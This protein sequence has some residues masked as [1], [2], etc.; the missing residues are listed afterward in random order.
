MR[1]PLDESV[2]REGGSRWYILVSD[3]LQS[4]K[5]CEQ[6]ANGGTVCEIAG[7]SM[8][9]SVLLLKQVNVSAN[10]LSVINF[11]D[12]RKRSRVEVN[13]QSL[14]GGFLRAFRVNFNG[15]VDRKGFHQSSFLYER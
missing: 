2:G 7:D 13:L 3:G 15:P 11:E 6:L 5:S 4:S 8:R 10:A 1:I 14:S 9:G 12:S